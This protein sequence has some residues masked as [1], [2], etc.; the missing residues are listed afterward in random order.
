[1]IKRILKRL[2]CRHVWEWEYEMTW[3]RPDEEKVCLGCH[4]VKCGLVKETN[5]FR[6][7]D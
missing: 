6:K 7:K 3:T 1:M 4:C 5:F 2:F